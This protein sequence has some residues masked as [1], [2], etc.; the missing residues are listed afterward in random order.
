MNLSAI[1]KEPEIMVYF[2]SSKYE[3]L[4]IYEAYAKFYR[5][6]NLPGLGLG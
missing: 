1:D 2:I 4:E 3:I 5:G 6:Y